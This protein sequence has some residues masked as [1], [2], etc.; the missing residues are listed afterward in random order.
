MFSDQSESLIALRIVKAHLSSKNVTAAN[1]PITRNMIS[2]VKAAR[3]RYFD[4]AKKE[5]RKSK[6]NQ[7]E[8][9][10]VTNEITDIQK[11]KARL[12]E[13]S[14]DL[15]KNADKLAFEAE[16]RNDLKLLGRS[17]DLRK[18]SRTKERARRL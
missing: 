11:K 16:T 3:A 14:N 1:I 6:Q 8:K 15:L 12:Q 13:S 5:R 10:V 4:Q 17:N 9:K 2:N 7:L 18:I